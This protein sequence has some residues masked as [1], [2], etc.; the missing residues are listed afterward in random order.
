VEPERDQCSTRVVL[1]DIPGRGRAALAALIADVAGVALVGEVGDV[2]GLRAMVRVISPDV[3]VVDDRLLIAPTD[4]ETRMIA[5]GADDDPG[6][7]A[8]AERLGAAA[9]I[10][11][12][13]ADE[14]LP[15]LLS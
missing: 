10:P 13:L 4:P 2:E 7:A 8:R 12:D 5:I 14:L 1:A 9:W 3:L 6:F 11:K 15:P